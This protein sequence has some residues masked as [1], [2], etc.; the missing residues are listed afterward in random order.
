[1]KKLIFM[2]G[3]VAMAAGVQAATI[4]WGT[5]VFK[6]P[7]ADGS[8]S[9]TATIGTGSGVTAY[10]FLTTAAGGVDASTLWDT[11]ATKG[12]D[13]FYT[14]SGETEKKSTFTAARSGG[15]GSTKFTATGSKDDVDKDATSYAS[16]IFTYDANNDGQIGEGDWYMVDSKSFVNSA[17]K[18]IEVNQLGSGTTWTK[19]TSPTPVIPEPTSGLLLLLG[20][21]GLAL[22]R[23][24][25]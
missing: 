15:G 4:T 23:K 17:D 1:M 2:L 16:I 5:A 24:Q 20:V 18:A 10:Y 11:Y 9:S 13:G 14:V 21:A 25:K 19:I 12:L 22:R 6:L 7:G 8:Q 3:A